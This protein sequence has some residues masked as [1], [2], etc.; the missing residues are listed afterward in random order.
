MTFEKLSK[1][2]INELGTDKLSDIALEFKVSPQ[3]VS[4][5]KSRNQVPYKYVKLL[6]EKLSRKNQSVSM[7]ESNFKN[8]LDYNNLDILDR[9]DDDEILVVLLDSITLIKSNYKIII[10]I[11][12]TFISGTYCYMSFFKTPLFISMSKIMPISSDQN[13]SGLGTIAQRFGVSLSAPTVSSSLS[14]A[15]M[16]PDLLNSRSLMRSL[17]FKKF[18]TDEFGQ[19]QA[20]INI[21]MGKKKK[22]N[23]WKEKHKRKAVSRLLSMINVQ[24]KRNSP[25][26]TLTS[27]TKE[28]KFSSDLLS[29]A[30]EELLNRVRAQKLSNTKETTKFISNRLIY[31]KSEL[32]KKEEA[33][34]Y[35]RERN[36]NIG[37]SPALLLEQERMIREMTTS[38][39]IYGSLKI[40]FE[41]T[42]IE[43]SRSLKVLEVLDPPEAPLK[44]FNINIYRSLIVSF[45]FGLI[46]SIFVVYSRSYY[47]KKVK[48]NL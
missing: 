31:I 25:L 33:L 13:K 20:L 7:G 15:E 24:K 46:V 47:L 34:K 36:R 17:L 28:S 10:A 26:L 38:N 4:N 11:L 37:S 41:K 1:L 22:S 19:N 39:Q 40:E 18:D 32:E 44:P 42:K 21:V 23:L 9:E 12:I 48:K 29:K 3:V 5:W 8:K 43:Q 30:I 27:I 2:M 6:R 14:S 45:I 16:F 35:F